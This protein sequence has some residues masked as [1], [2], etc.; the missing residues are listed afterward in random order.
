MNLKNRKIEE[1]EN[2]KYLNCCPPRISIFSCFIL[3]NVESTL[4]LESSSSSV[5]PRMLSIVK[6]ENW[7]LHK[8]NKFL[9][10]WV[11]TKFQPQTYLY[12]K[13]YFL[14][15]CCVP[16]SLLPRFQLLRCLPPLGRLSRIWI[17]PGCN[18]LPCCQH[19]HNSINEEALPWIWN[20]V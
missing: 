18:T 1:K 13:P 15:S 9:Y 4:P 12:W 19:N 16:S 10:I 7:S 3:V 14:F 11:K 6:L 5:S 8:I 20:L 17:L 2:T